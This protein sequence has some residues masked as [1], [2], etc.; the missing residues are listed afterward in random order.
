MSV[1][2]NAFATDTLDLQGIQVPYARRGPRGAPPILVLHGGGGPVSNQPALRGLS[3]TFDV[4]A[5]VHPGFAGTSL[6]PDFDGME[7][8]VYL[9]LDFIDALELSE[10]TLMGF[11]LGGW[12]ATELA[13]RNSSRLSRLVLVDPVG[14]K[15]GGREDRDIADVFATPADELVRRQFHDPANA[16]DLRGLGDRELAILAS[17]RTALALYG[18]EPYMHNPKLPGRMHRINLPTLLLWG[19]S[20]GVVS[21]D[22]GRAFQ[23]LIEGA[24][25]ELIAGAG[26]QP[27][28]EQPEAW[29]EALREFLG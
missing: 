27:H 26:H 2:A 12:C 24:Q 29:L 28:V 23:R 4:I 18:W 17:N 19:E 22:Y 20:D 5:P 25:L 16:P 13:V 6:P 15:P 11:S 9:Y 8:L 10:I 21:V 14:I 1:D 7:D 3:D